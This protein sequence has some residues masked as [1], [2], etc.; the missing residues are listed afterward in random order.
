MLIFSLTIWTFVWTPKRHLFWNIFEAVKKTCITCF[1]KTKTLSYASCFYTLN[2]AACFLNITYCSPMTWQPFL[3]MLL[4][5][6]INILVDKAFTNNWFNQT[7]DLNLEKEELTQF[8]EV[9]TTNQL[10]QFVRSMG[11]PLG[12]LMANVFLCHLDN[13]LACEG[14]VPSIQEV[15]WWHSCQNA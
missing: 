8:L 9:C 4:S 7:H 2:S 3:P 6:T 5:E 12:P 10:F 15:C 1:I 13:K 14:M 11:S